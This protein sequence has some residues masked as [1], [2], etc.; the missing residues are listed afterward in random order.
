MSLDLHLALEKE[1]ATYKQASASLDW[2]EHCLI[3]GNGKLLSGSY[4]C[5]QECATTTQ[6]LSLTVT[7]WSGWLE[8]SKLCFGDALEIQAWPWGCRKSWPCASRPGL[9]D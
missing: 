7:S 3:F 6:T 2:H 1:E 8:K 4:L 9:T 5:C